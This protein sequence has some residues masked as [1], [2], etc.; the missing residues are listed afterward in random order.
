MFD[1]N[2]FI[3]NCKGRP[4]SAVKQLIEEAL[5]DPAAV[6][7]ALDAEFTGRDLSKAGLANL[8]CFRSPTLTVLKAATPP[9]FKRPR[10]I[11]ICGQ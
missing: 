4:A 3:E 6:K 2:E 1:L 10:I 7:A 5:R 11:T 9:K 8:I